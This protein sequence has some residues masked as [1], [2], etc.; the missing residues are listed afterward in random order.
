MDAPY[1]LGILSRC[2]HRPRFACRSPLDRPVIQIAAGEIIVLCGLMGARKTAFAVQHFISQRDAVLTN[3]P[4]VN[5][6]DHVQ[7]VGD[8]SQGYSAASNCL[9]IWDEAGAACCTMQR[10]AL[11]RLCAWAA[12][13]RHRQ[14]SVVLIC[15]NSE[16]L[17]R[18]LL[19]LTSKTIRLTD[20]ASRLGGFIKALNRS[21]VQVFAGYRYTHQLEG[22]NKKHGLLRA[23]LSLPRPLTLSPYSNL[24][25]LAMLPALTSNPKSSVQCCGSSPPCLLL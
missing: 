9:L 8:M 6:P 4:L 24:L 7:L 1:V 10:A 12:T 23:L 25:T 5:P 2:L 11:D 13:I 19:F 18:R 15:Q 20:I 3:I 16:Q 17:D 21:S 22:K 14:I